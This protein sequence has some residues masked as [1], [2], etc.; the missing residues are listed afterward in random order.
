M[1]INEFR[2]TIVNNLVGVLKEPVHLRPVCDFHYLEVLPPT[3]KK[4]SNVAMPV[5]QQNEDQERISLRMW[6]L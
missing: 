1:A 5:L 4:T 3:E 2:E 6:V